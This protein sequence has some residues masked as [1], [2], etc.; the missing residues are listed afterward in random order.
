[1]M[2]H[3][4]LIVLHRPPLSLQFTRTPVV[5]ADFEICWASVTAIIKLIKQ[6]A[7]GNEYLYLPMTFI[8]TATA[9]ASIVLLKRHIVH[10][11]SDEEAAKFLHVILDAL[12]GCSVTWTA[13]AQA[14]Q[15]ILMADEEARLKMAEFQVKTEGD[16]DTNAAGLELEQYFGLEYDSVMGGMGMGVGGVVGWMDPDWW[17]EEVPQQQEDVNMGF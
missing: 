9:A 5:T 6:Y 10:E 15:A 4:V 1:M 11:E 12:E 3:T 14:K 16:C 7:R 13:A 8:H 17:M 2:Y